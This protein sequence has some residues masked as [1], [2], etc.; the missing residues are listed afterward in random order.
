MRK[1]CCIDILGKIRSRPLCAR[2]GNYP[3]EIDKHG[4]FVVQHD[5]DGDGIDDTVV[6]LTERAFLNMTEV[7]VDISNM[8]IRA[9]IFGGLADVYQPQAHH[10]WWTVLERVKKEARRRSRV[11]KLGVL[12]LDI[13]SV[14][15]AHE[16]ITRPYV[17]TDA[18]ADARFWLTPDQVAQTVVEE[19]SCLPIGQVVERDLYRPLPYFDVLY[20]SDEQFTPRKVVERHGRPQT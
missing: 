9:A 6:Q 4:Q 16:I 1:I 17:F 2:V 11:S 12:F 7:L 18:G 5:A 14:V 20:Y 19:M 10:S 3:S 13:S 8:P 15:C